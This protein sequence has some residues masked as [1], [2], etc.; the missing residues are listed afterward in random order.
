MALVWKTRGFK[1]TLQATCCTVATSVYNTHTDNSIII[2]TYDFSIKSV[3]GYLKYNERY[4]NKSVKSVPSRRE[5]GGLLLGTVAQIWV[6]FMSLP[7]N[8]TD[9]ME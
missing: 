9:Y 1:P 2:T 3:L 5:G 7:L 8:G 6:F 4:F